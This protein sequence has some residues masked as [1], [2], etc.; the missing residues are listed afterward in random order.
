MLLSNSGFVTHLLDGLLL[1]PE[2]PRKD[3]DETVKTAVQR[4]FAECIQQISLFPPGCEALKEN[5]AI[6]QALSILKDKAW[7]E[8]ARICAA[9]A[10]IALMPPEPEPLLDGEE[11]HVMLSYQWDHQSQVTRAHDLLTKLGIKCWMDIAGGMGQDIY[12]SMAEGV[13]NASAVVC[14]MSQKYQD[15]PNCQLELK[16][17]RQSGVEIVPVM[18]EGGGWRGVT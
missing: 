16:F 8:E 3:T 11:K 12:D 9:G 1:D 7:S 17:A 6:I 15:S 13:S 4:D 18:M 5:E 10:L 14:F 2:H